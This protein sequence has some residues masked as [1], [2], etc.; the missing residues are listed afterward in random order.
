MTR[1]P[2]SNPIHNHQKTMSPTSATACGSVVRGS[3]ISA[4]WRALVGSGAASA[5][6]RAS[7]N[8]NF[9][10]SIAGKASPV[11]DTVFANYMLIT[12]LVA[13]QYTAAG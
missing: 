7:I 10:K 3:A 1:V 13:R 11:V 2:L 12:P 5:G 8:A 9:Q 4:A 6:A